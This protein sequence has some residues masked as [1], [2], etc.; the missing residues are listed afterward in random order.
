MIILKII[1]VLLKI[2]GVI[3]LIILAAMCIP[4][5]IGVV[6]DSS[7]SIRVKY[8]L[9]KY[10]FGDSDEAKND[11]PKSY[12]D[13]KGPEIVKRVLLA[14]LGS[15]LWIFKAIKKLFSIIAKQFKHSVAALKEK[16]RKKSTHVKKNATD[17]DEESKKDKPKQ[18]IFSTLREERSFWGAVKFF[19]DIGKAF[20]GT[21]AKGYRGVAIDK[22]TLRLDVSGE[23]AADTAIKYGEACSVIFPA[24]SFL[25]V[26]ARR[27]NHDIEINPNFSN[28]G[29]R[30]YFDGEFVIYPILIIAHLVGAVV[31]FLVL[32][33]KITLENKKRKAE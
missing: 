14:V 30:L 4:V 6:Y 20:G 27:Y 18:S 17:E 9:L 16:Y 13:K 10:T 12:T 24:L 1:G 26:N 32:Q 7:I 8:L 3:L 11:K 23:D 21:V 33:I 25:L 2:I 19:V 31:G 29:N 22:F 28:D 15:V 5:R